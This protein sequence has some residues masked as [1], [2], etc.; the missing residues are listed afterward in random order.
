MIICII[1]G[2]NSIKNRFYSLTD[3]LRSGWVQV[4]KQE[5]SRLFQCKNRN[6]EVATIAVMSLAMAVFGVTG[7]MTTHSTHKEIG[8]H[9]LSGDPPQ[10]AM[11]DFSIMPDFAFIPPK[12]DDHHKDNKSCRTSVCTALMEVTTSHIISLPDN[13]DIL[14]QIENQA[15]YYRSHQNHID[16]SIKRAM[17]I[18]PLI[19][20]KLQAAGLPAE[21]ALL[22]IIE[23]SYQTDALSS[24]DAAGLW[25]ITPTTGRYLGLNR[26]S[27]FDGRMDINQST[28]AAIDYLA[29]LHKAFGNDW[30]KTLMAYN[31]GSGTLQK[32]IAGKAQPTDEM[33]Q[34]PIRFYALVMIFNEFSM[35]DISRYNDK[36]VRKINLE[37]P[38]S[39]PKIADL[40]GVSLNELQRLNPCYKTG[41]TLGGSWLMIPGN[42]AIAFTSA[43]IKTAER[44]ASRWHLAKMKKKRHV[45]E[46]A[47]DHHCSTEELMAMN[48]I[49]SPIL[50]KGDEILVP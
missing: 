1:V 29:K 32:V 27:V 34:Y 31:G 46:I 24:H 9:Q 4:D 40:T 2:M 45:K 26:S 35:S 5:S 12:V 41:L 36:R 13:P 8:G 20:G 37:K 19:V 7:V 14:G 16:K 33:S 22:P 25:Q 50:Q 28:D 11:Y 15:A 23:S 30:T 21:L 10:S 38:I 47:R 6:N 18:L 49:D 3:S 42:D 43:R 39:L 17:P 44:A 48:H